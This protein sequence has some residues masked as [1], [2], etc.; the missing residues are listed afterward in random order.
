MASVCDLKIGFHVAM[1][2]MGSYHKLTY[3]NSREAFLS[4]Y[5]KG[6]R[7]FEVDL[8]EAEDGQFV[9]IAHHVTY[10]DLKRVGISEIPEHITSEWF[11][12]QKLFPNMSK[13]LTPLSLEDLVDLL[14]Q[15]DDV[16]LML[17]LFG[18]F[19]E[20]I[21]ENFSRRL[22]HFVGEDTSVMDRLLIETYNEEM[23]AVIS[24]RI[25]RAHIIYGIDDLAT[26][27]GNAAFSIE[28]MKEM[29]IEFVSFPW[30]YTVKYPGRLKEL[31]ENGLT[32]FSRTLDNLKEDTLRNAGVRVL[33]I[34]RYY[35]R[36][37]GLAYTQIYIYTRTH[38]VWSLV[39]S[40]CKRKLLDYFHGMK[41]RTGGKEE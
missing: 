10:K 32:V 9:C 11:L 7:V 20:R 38:Y 3:T 23:T 8:A 1:H 12:R 31:V 34:D 18:Q 25:P 33:L 4:W 30:H 17:D 6:I 15:Y 16:V 40:T 36:T 22:N 24:K 21:L 28:R 37:R 39:Y 5:A 26:G 2:A 29:G 13:G 14:K 35:E 19:E 27:A 41:N